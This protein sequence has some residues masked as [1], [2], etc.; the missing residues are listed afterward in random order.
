LYKE[1][2]NAQCSNIVGKQP[3]HLP[4]KKTYFSIVGGIRQAFEATALLRTVNL[5]IHQYGYFRGMQCQTPKSLSAS[6]R[7]TT[8][9]EI[10]TLSFGIY[11]VW[12]VPKECSFVKPATRTNKEAHLA[13]LLATFSLFEVYI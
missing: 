4:S 11:A 13:F 7:Q 8:K 5:V 10:F 2:I 6:G 1:I 9:S 12:I 3:S